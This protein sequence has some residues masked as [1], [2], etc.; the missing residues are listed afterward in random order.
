M[1]MRRASSLIA[2]AIACC[3]GWPAQAQDYPAHP[4]RIIVPTQAGGVSDILS[5]TFAN[6]VQNATG[7]TVVVENRTGANGVLAADY[8]AKSTPDG[9]TVYLGFQGTQSVLPHVEPKLP[10]DPTRDF[11]PVVLLATGPAV[12]VVHPSMPAR[13]VK[14]LVELAKAKPG[15]YSYASAGF[16]TTHHLAAEMFKLAAG[17]DLTGVTYRG[18]APANQD[19]I[20]GHVPIEFDNLG[21]AVNNIRSGAVRPLA[22]TAKDR[23]PLLPDVPTMAEAGYPSV[24]AQSWFAFFVPAKT[25]R[26]AIDWLNRQ[27]NEV[28]SDPAMRDQF[29]RQGLVLPL[30]SPEFLGQHVAEETQRWGEVIRKAKITLP[31]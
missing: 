30:G 15:A 16:G 12:L 23:S 9:Y 7:A 3:L 29:L 1:A 14:E 8:V 17:V 5:R 18:A 13:S 21:L 20:A 22:I 10:Y 6:K 31:N 11:A 28:F 19:V 27:A 24:I 4:I 2:Y 26:P 25:P